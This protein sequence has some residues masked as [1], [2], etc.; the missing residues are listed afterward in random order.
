MT[1]SSRLHHT[2]LTVKPA[3]ERGLPAAIPP[4]QALLPDGT[5]AG[6]SQAARQALPDTLS[7]NT[8]RVYRSALEGL[9]ERLAGRC[10]CDE[11]LSEVLAQMSALGLSESA[12]RIAVA[13][14]NKEAELAGL[15][16]PCGRSTTTVLRAHARKAP[17]PRQATAIDWPAAD[18][19]AALAS[20]AQRPGLVGLR[21]AALIGVMSDAAL[22]VSEASAI[23][24]ADLARRED[25]SATL[26][27]RRSKTDQDGHGAVLYLGESTMD[28]IDAW[29]R[30]R[31]QCVR[32]RAA[33]PGRCRR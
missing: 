14:V 9:N 1:D 15:E 4:Q 6:L 24:V 10:V 23:N 25:G 31:G 11:H 8:K 28:R 22:R 30:R 7:E 20:K 32:L 26:L 5:P 21:D 18:L 16:S 33:A 27:I 29:R 17:P 3:G 2:D 19:A 12:L 13:A